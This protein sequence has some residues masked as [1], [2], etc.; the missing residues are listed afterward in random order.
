MRLLV[1]VA[2]WETIA[3]ITSFG[4]VTLWKLFQSASFAGLLR[5]S[6]GTLSPGRIQL[7]VLTVLTALQYLL[8]TIHDPSRLPTLSTG[9]LVAL[10]GSQIVY[11]AAKAWS[12]FGF[13]RN[14]LEER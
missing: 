12:F 1:N 10:G 11:L 3:L 6:N 4:I 7:L 13:K 5:S 2:R 8:T 9:L 14:T